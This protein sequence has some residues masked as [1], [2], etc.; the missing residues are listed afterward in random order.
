MLRRSPQFPVTGSRVAALALL[1]VLA[2]CAGEGLSAAPPRPQTPWRDAESGTPV[3]LSLSGAAGCELIFK[4]DGA[5]TALA[6]A[7]PPGP[8][9]VRLWDRSTGRLLA[10]AGVSCAPSWG[11]TPLRRRVLVSAGRVYWVLV[12]VGPAGGAQRVGL[13]ANFPGTFG[14]SQ[15]ARSLFVADAKKPF[16]KSPIFFLDR[17]MG[18]ADVT[19]E[20]APPPVAAPAPAPAPI[21]TPAPAPTPAPTPPPAA[22]PTLPPAT[23][24][25]PAPVPPPAAAPVPPPIPAPPVAPAPAP[26]PAPV[27]PPLPVRP[28][29]SWREVESGTAAPLSLRGAAGF[30]FV[31][32][33]DGSVRALAAQGGTG[34]RL[35]WLYDRETGRLLAQASVPSGPGWRET[36]LPEAVPVSASHR[37]CVL[38]EVG[39]GGGGQHVASTVALPRVSGDVRIVQTIFA[40]DGKKPFA[41]P[42]VVYVDRMLGQ[43]DI[44]FVPA[45]AAA[46]TPVPIP[47]P[48][49]TPAPVPPPVAAPAPPPAP[50]PEPARP[51]Q[52]TVLAVSDIGGNQAVVEFSTDRPVTALVRFGRTLEY[53]SVERVDAAPATHHRVALRP[54]DGLSEYRAQIEVAD[55]AGL[56]SRS[57]DLAFTTGSPGPS[58]VWFEGS[59]L[60]VR[61]RN[62]DGSLAAAAPY[63]IKGVVYGFA[64]DADTYSSDPHNTDVRRAASL[65]WYAKDL[66]LIL[67][68]NANTARFTMD[69]GVDAITGPSGWKFL[70]DLYAAGVMVILTTDDT[71][72]DTARIVKVIEYYRQHPAILMWS[73]GSEVNINRYWGTAPS[74]L[75]AAR[76]AELAAR[77]VHSLD[78]VHPV[79]ASWGEIDFG[80]PGS[81]T[82]LADTG[83]YVN[84][85]CPSVD[86]FALNI[87]R[88]PSFGVLFSQW[89]S[90]T[91]K[92][93]FFGEFTGADAYDGR[94]DREDDGPQADRTEALWNEVARNFSSRDPRNVAL[95]ACF[96]ELRDLLWKVSPPRVQGLGGWFT[97]H[98]PDGFMSEEWLGC[99]T[100]DGRARRV[101]S[102]L[103]RLFDAAYAPPVLPRPAVSYEARSAGLRS[104]EYAW[105]QG[106]IRLLVGGALVY[107]R[108]GGGGGARGFTVF[109]IS[110]ETGELQ[111]TRHFDTWG[112]FGMRD[113]LVDY[114]ESLP[115]GTPLLIGVGDEAGLT[116]SGSRDSEFINDPSVDRLLRALE[117]LGSAQIRGYRYWSSWA[118]SCVKGEGRA[119]MEGL[120]P[121]Q[122]VSVRL[123]VAPR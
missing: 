47:P 22:A 44:Q 121:D 94:L 71:V 14:D 96:L 6:A 62:L 74:V 3:P 4:V 82:T 23:A 45:R 122:P 15:I 33:V 112:V 90:I 46:P 109:R 102:V 20:P 99:F 34:A 66:P 11:S 55:A 57:A 9:M 108:T 19:F 92:P 73:L 49:P 38:V 18:L 51:P 97:L 85:V 13:A 2:V 105:Q 52:I 83:F 35:V 41:K 76:R 64:P 119:R 61:K 98:C 87:F 53:G 60:M 86:C 69:P 32:G 103:A 91:S 1:P 21:P 48:T 5:V 65:P 80:A 7:G 25:I 113:A 30:E 72:N 89:K 120:S 81:G 67:R 70:S 106:F 117:S 59:V 104:Q 100:A 93:M 56:V 36:S 50:A 68:L 37:Y 115:V 26:A 63:D 123:E 24:P 95:G 111:E 101:V 28:Q 17:M 54:L 116:Y 79:V 118:M 16:S 31:P 42:L 107:G 58:Q 8:R 88:G 84:V 27:L 12:D 78:E 75:E 39:S 29:N 114:L 77:L 43:A 10:E 110:A 40:A